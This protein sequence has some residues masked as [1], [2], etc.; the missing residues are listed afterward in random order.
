[1]RR[2]LL[3]LLLLPLPAFADT[4]AQL[5][6]PTMPAAQRGTEDMVLQLVR[7]WQQQE[8]QKEQALDASRSAHQ[9]MAAVTKEKED[10]VAELQKAQAHV[11]DL[12][13]LTQDLQ[14]KMRLQQQKTQSE[15]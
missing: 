12:E 4:P 3:A 5:P 6:P 10:V 9:A 8:I 14:V 15:N 13:M 7:L 1:M 2:A 11:K